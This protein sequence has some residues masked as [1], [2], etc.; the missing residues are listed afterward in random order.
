VLLDRAGAKVQQFN[1]TA[2]ITWSRPDG[3]TS[4]PRVLAGVQER[5][6]F[7]PGKPFRSFP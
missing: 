4:S 6:T 7:I 3:R 1:R 5:R 2:T